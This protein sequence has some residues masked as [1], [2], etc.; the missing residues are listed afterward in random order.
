MNPNEPDRPLQQISTLWTVVCQA[1]AGAPEAVR[2]A[3]EQLLRRYRGA[4]S[5]Y[6]LAA[7]RDAAA[8]EDLAQEFALRFLQG[9]LRGA[10]P[11]QGRFRDFL[12]G[13]LAHL[14]ADHHR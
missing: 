3:Q 7:V 11:G 6:L 9:R 10:D 2:A 4:V 1:H 8:A 13:V 12:K 5:R 14:V